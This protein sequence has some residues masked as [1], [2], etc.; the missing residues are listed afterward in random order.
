MI[1][2]QQCGTPSSKIILF[3]VHEQ[4]S[5]SSSGSDGCTGYTMIVPRPGSRVS[6]CVCSV[7]TWPSIG[8]ESHCLCA[9]ECPLFRHQAGTGWRAAGPGPAVT[10][11]AY[12]NSCVAVFIQFGL[13]HSWLPSSVPA[14]SE[15]HQGVSVKMYFNV[16][17]A[18]SFRF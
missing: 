7:G 2:E 16:S 11:R 5:S 10:R 13:N 15:F 6:V 14:L 17:L 3:A 12:A 8:P 9:R 4:R 18:R 1:L